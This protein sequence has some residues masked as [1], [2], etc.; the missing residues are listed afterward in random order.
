M[1]SFE[2][3]PFTSDTCKDNLSLLDSCKQS[4]GKT[5]VASTKRFQKFSR[6]KRFRKS[7]KVNES[8]STLVE[9]EGV[10]QSLNNHNLRISLKGIYDTDPISQ[11][12]KIFK[13]RYRVTP[14]T[15]SHKSKN[16]SF[17]FPSR[18]K[19]KVDSL[20]HHNEAD[21]IMNELK[22]IKSPKVWQ[23][24]VQNFKNK[25]STLMDLIPIE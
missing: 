3:L 7:S 14:T 2:D 11:L 4:Q 20:F 1:E 12:K 25:P 18:K 16:F 9:H 19:S 5:I 6:N 15:Q 17:E 10:S 21:F 24:V 22:T 13:A 23:Q 8:I